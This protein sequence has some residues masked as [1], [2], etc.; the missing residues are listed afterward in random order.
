MSRGTEETARLRRNVE[1]QLGRLLE[2]LADLDEFAA[3]LADA[4]REE[5]RQDTL[6]ALE[7]MKGNL[8]KM[9]SGNMT[10]VTEFGRLQ[11]AIQAAVSSAFKTPEVLRMFAAKNGG[12]LRARLA[13]VVRDE[14]LGK[15]APEAAEA[16]KV[17]LLAALRSLGETLSE[18]EAAF[19]EQ[20]LQQQMTGFEGASAA[21][22]ASNT[23]DRLLSAAASSIKKAQR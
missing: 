9:M 20:R 14:R 10:L 22:I 8:A 16:L 2:Q 5:M 11:L 3:E 17:E 23:Q 15:M 21:P 1:E 12:Q 18:E 6:E 7:E 4:E 19:L 13:A